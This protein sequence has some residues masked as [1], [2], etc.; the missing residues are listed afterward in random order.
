MRTAGA[1]LLLG[2][3]SLQ[4]QTPP[5]IRVE[6]RLV[7]VGV[8]VV[9]SHGRHVPGL[10]RENF[11][12]LDQNQPQRITSFAAVEPPSA[13][14]APAPPPPADAQ[15][16]WTNRRSTPPAP[17][18][19]LTIILLDRLNT[20]V[21]DQTAAKAALRRFLAQ[22]PPGAMALYLLSDRLYRLLDVTYDRQAMLAA[23]DRFLP[24]ENRAHML[25]DQP[26]SRTG[27][28]IDWIENLV[29]SRLNAYYMPERRV[30]P[31]ENAMLLL[32]AIFSQIPG[33]KNLIWISGGCALSTGSA[34]RLS[35]ASIAVYPVDAH[36]VTEVDV[37]MQDHQ[38]P[39]APTFI[40]GE[41]HDPNEPA[42]F[43]PDTGFLYKVAG[44]AQATGGEAL[45]G[46][47]DL[48][49]QLRKAV[50]DGRGDYL[51]AFHPDTTRWDGKYHPLR[52]TV[53]RPGLRV[54]ARAGYLA[55]D[56]L[57][58]A[59]AQL[60]MAV[61]NAAESAALPIDVFAPRSESTLNVRVQ[62][63]CAAIAFEQAQDKW[64]ARLKLVFVQLDGAGKSMGDTEQTLD[65]S[66]GDVAYEQAR[67]EGLRFTTPVALRDGA[68][69][70]RI[71]LQDL[72]TGAIGSLTIQLVS[73]TRA[74]GMP[75]PYGVVKNTTPRDGIST[76]TPFAKFAL[77][78][79]APATG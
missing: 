38:L 33:R 59:A 20:A 47:N 13:N 72:S 12:L 28:P 37:R 25:S 75:G 31:T 42:L 19:P 74:P 6:S 40:G 15:G 34:A 39:F 1:L 18:P 32:A 49:S 56:V 73:A 70:L 62:V 2:L 41:Y 50:D 61:E 57:P 21:G 78:R 35:A 24:A 71:L 55:M 10:T 11:S 58:D 17:A 67:R 43:P 23:A 16:V 64:V 8:S 77:A 14:A 5:V 36:G 63:P 68:A 54:Q 9:D 66:L 46:S 69:R 30:L 4:A 44:L 65:V 7:E 60:R 79:V 52:V 51:L 29:R 48:A 45:T 27:L 22:S 76:L 3:W 26:P 53:N